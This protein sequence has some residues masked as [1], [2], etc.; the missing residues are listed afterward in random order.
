MDYRKEGGPQWAIRVT[1]TNGWP[2][3]QHTENE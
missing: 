2:G 1:E 3:K